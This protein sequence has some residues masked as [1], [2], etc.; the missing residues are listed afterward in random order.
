[1]QSG[2]RPHEREDAVR[3]ELSGPVQ[4]EA[5]LEA[6]ASVNLLAGGED[7]GARKTAGGEMTGEAVALVFDTEADGTG[8]RFGDRL[9]QPPQP[10]DP[11][12]VRASDRAG[13]HVDSR[14]RHA[15]SVP[16]RVAR[17]W[18]YPISSPV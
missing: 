15:A 1:M 2:T 3:E 5:F 18:R 6:E 12:G 7:D 16:W 11:L 10:G 13:G 8:N 4:A 9:S 14:F 17:L